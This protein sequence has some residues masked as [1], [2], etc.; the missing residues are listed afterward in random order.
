[1]FLGCCFCLRTAHRAPSPRRLRID[2]FCCVLDDVINVLTS[3]LECGDDVSVRLRES[4]RYKVHFLGERRG[5]SK[6]DVVYDESVEAK[7]TIDVIQGCAT[8]PLVDS[9]ETR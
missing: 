4:Q 7:E 6:N 9:N 3:V 5:V 1:M 2:S 8:D